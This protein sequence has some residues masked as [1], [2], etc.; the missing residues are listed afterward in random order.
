MVRGL[1]KTLWKMW[2]NKLS[3]RK[4][5]CHIDKNFSFRKINAKIID[6]VALYTLVQNFVEN[7]KNACIDGLRNIKTYIV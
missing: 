4:I 2:I 5:N 6:K 7:V 3:P 1:F